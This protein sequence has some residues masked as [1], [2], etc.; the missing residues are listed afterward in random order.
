MPFHCFC[1]YACES[2]RFSMA[3]GLLLCGVYACASVLHLCLHARMHVCS[4]HACVWMHACV[5][6]WV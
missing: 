6:E 5:C 1:L 2:V 3:A 4:M